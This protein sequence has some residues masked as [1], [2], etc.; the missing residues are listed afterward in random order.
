MCFLVNFSNFKNTFYIQHLRTIVFENLSKVQ[1][2]RD[3]YTIDIVDS[4]NKTWWIFQIILN[5]ESIW[6]R[7]NHEIIPNFFVN[8]LERHKPNHR[9]RSHDLDTFSSF[10]FS[11]HRKDI[12]KNFLYSIILVYTPSTEKHKA[13][14]LCI[15]ICFTQYYSIE[16]VS[17]FDNG[18]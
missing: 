7:K 10:V 3:F 15:Q 16:F 1:K 2:S 12:N 17:C 4:H 8:F 14:N 9:K 5:K 6:F 18:S 11:L 13:D